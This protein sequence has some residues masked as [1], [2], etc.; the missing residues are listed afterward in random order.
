MID[1][2]LK[3]RGFWIYK[4]TCL[5]N[6]KIY[7][8]QT[9]TSI[10]NRFTGHFTDCK[11]RNNDKKNRFYNALLLYGKKNFKVELVLKGYC[12]DELNFLEEHYINYYNSTNRNIGYNTFKGG[13]NAKHTIE[14]KQKI[15]ESKKYLTPEQKENIR[16]GQLGRFTSEETKKLQSEVK[17]GKCYL[18]EESKLVLSTKCSYSRRMSP[19]TKSNTTGF[20]GVTIMKSRY[21]TKFQSTIYYNGNSVVL[22]YFNTIE[23]AA[24]AYNDAVDKYWEGN[25]YKNIINE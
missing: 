19:P 11:R 16:N 12:I 9:T 17:M 1:N 24:Q 6:G 20:K 22:G 13:K 7:I 15:R 14:T 21:T 23:E 8:G 2:I 25:G 4:I 10:L 18:T 3:E 5:I